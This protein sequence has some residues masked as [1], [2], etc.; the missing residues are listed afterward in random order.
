MYVLLRIYSNSVVVVITNGFT[1][2]SA[3][4]SQLVEYK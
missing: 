3:G 1:S 4:T 2:G